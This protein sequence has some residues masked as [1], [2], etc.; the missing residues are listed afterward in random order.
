MMLLACCK[1]GDIERA[2]SFLDEMEALGVKPDVVT[3]NLVLR[4]A[5]EAPLW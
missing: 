5:A 4:S 1:H 2:L 3:Y